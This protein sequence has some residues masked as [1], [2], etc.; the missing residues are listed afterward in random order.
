MKT[1]KHLRKVY[2]IAKKQGVKS[3]LKYDLKETSKRLVCLVIATEL[4]SG[5]IK[6]EPEVYVDYL[7]REGDK[8]QLRRKGWCPVS[9]ALHNGWISEE[10]I[11][12]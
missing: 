9:V 2:S 11:N 5:K 7:E 10:E 1:I 3:A 6:P 8:Y 4:Y 12:K